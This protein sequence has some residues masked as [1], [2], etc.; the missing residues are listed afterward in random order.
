MPSPPSLLP[1]PVKA[2]SPADGASLPQAIQYGFVVKTDQALEMP[3]GIEVAT[4]PTLGQDGTLAQE[5][6]VQSTYFAHGDAFPDT[7]TANTAPTAKP[8][9]PG[10]YY[11][12][13][14][15]QTVMRYG[16]KWVTPVYRFVVTPPASTPAP[17][18]PS[19]AKPTRLPTLSHSDAKRLMRSALKRKFK[20]TYRH[21]DA[22][23]LAGLLAHFADPCPLQ[24]RVVGYRRPR[25]PG[26]DHDLA[27]P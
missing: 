8:W 16:A 17:P 4:A 11:W 15:S 27:Q 6:V 24:P 13:A 18:Q 5:Y 20:N 21:G 2:I 3:L 14:S 12:Q 25:L 23:R 22:K 1:L 7:Y 10:T 26:L 9:A 19:P